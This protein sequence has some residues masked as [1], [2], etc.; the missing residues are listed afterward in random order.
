MGIS[1]L[2]AQIDGIDDRLLQLLQERAEVAAQIAQYKKTQGSALFHDPERERYLLA[3]VAKKGAGRFPLAAIR[4]VFREVMSGCLSVEEPL[5]VGFLGP[6]GTFSHMAARH[7]FGLAARYRET[8]SIE[9]VF[10]SVERG[11]AT[12]GVVPVENSTAGCISNTL[13][14]LWE[15]SLLIRQELVLA[16]SHCL[17]GHSNGLS[18]VERVYS[19][20]HALS[21]CRLWL[22]QH[23]PAAKWVHTSSTAAAAQEAKNDPAGAAIGSQL[24]SELYGLP[25]LREHIQDRPENATRFL[26]IGKADSPKSGDDK[27]TVAFSVRDERGALRQVLEVFERAEINLSRI[28]SRPSGVRAWAYVFFAD[29]SGH[30]EDERVAAAIEKLKGQCATVKVL[31]SYPRYRDGVVAG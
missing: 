7:L 14:A 29:I 26:V 23:V 31:G 10:D 19:H 3:R 20:P 9:G 16:V 11:A 24:C 17:L 21:Q 5:G 27:T 25:L 15:G 12:Y 18:A 30:R 28:E 22:A 4:A 6:E 8:P 13:D 2:R 1:D